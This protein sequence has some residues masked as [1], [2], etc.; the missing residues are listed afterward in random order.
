MTM[1]SVLVPNATAGFS[2]KL[3]FE[4]ISVDYPGDIREDAR[5]GD[6][7]ERLCRCQPY[8]A[9]AGGESESEEGLVRCL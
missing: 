8:Y 2:S 3:A 5:G 4:A 7:G 9:T 1:P 6:G